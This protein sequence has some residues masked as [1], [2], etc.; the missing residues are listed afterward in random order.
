M[1]GYSAKQVVRWRKVIIQATVVTVGRV[2]SGKRGIEIVPGGVN[3]R[4]A[5]VRSA[6]CWEK[7][8]DDFCGCAIDRDCGWVDRC[9]GHRIRHNEGY[10]P[11]ANAGEVAGGP[12]GRQRLR[13]DQ[14]ILIESNSLVVEIE[15]QFVLQDWGGYGRSKGVGAQGRI[16]LRDAVGRVP[17]LSREKPKAAA[18]K[19]VGAAAGDDGK[20][21]G[22]CELGAIAGGIYPEFRNAFDRR[23]QIRA[24]SSVAHV[25]NGNAVKGERS[26]GRQLS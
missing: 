12:A 4:A 7:V 8:A 3:V 18:V 24:G 16:E 10:G 1:L 5:G 23:K 6:G 20:V 2:V 11:S 13:G 22:L 15:V 25:L 19:F 9:V 26:G 17:I 21:G 14:R